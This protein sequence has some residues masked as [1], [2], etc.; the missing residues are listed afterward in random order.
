MIGACHPVID[1]RVGFAEV[2]G[3]GEAVLCLHTAGQSGVQWRET[4][5]QLPGA[6]YRVI[7]PDLPGHGRSDAAAAGPIDDLS[8][9][10][11]WCRR[12]LAAL[13]VG[14][15]Y[16]VGCSIGGRI[17]LD[18]AARAPELALGVVA[19]EANAASGVLS[20]AGL[21]RELEDASSPSRGDR[22]FYGTLASLGGALAPARAAELAARHRREDPVVSTAD[23]IGWARHRLDGA[24]ERIAAPVHLVAGE[25]DFWLDREVLESM[26]RQIT[27]CTAEVLP[28]VGHYPMEELPDFPGTLAG[29]LARLGAGGAEERK[30]DG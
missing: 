3:E 1:G 17:A 2:A 11:E 28:G 21:E 16:L 14:R 4:L 13:G 22:T 23:L 10:A 15:A 20:P 7:V 18:L 26:R 30:R 6:G 9:Y 12:L 27:N 5:Q 29:W 25:D 19:M 8:L 24:L